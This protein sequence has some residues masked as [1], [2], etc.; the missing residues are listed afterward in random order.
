MS[1]VY[2]AVQIRQNTHQIS[3]GIEADELSAFER[4][5]QA[6]QNLR[7]SVIHNP[8]VAE[9]FV[10]GLKNFE[11]LSEVEQFRFGLLLRNWFSAYHG[12]YMRQLSL[13]HDPLGLESIGRLIDKMLIND[14]AREWLEHAD[15]DWRPEFRS[16]IE[17]RLK[18][19]KA[20]GAAATSPPSI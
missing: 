17:E 7:E 2:I 18:G 15:P 12:G 20:G 11:R 14:G 1:L 16:F 13:L 9:L 5:V 4:N 8:E 6:G 19:V 3:R 10:K